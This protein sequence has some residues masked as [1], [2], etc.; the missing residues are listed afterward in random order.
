MPDTV[1]HLFLELFHF[2]FIK[3]LWG[4]HPHSTEDIW[5]AIRNVFLYQEHLEKVQVNCPRSHSSH[6]AQVAL[7]SRPDSPIQ[8]LTMGRDA[9]GKSANHYSLPGISVLGQRTSQV[10]NQG[11][12]GCRQKLLIVREGFSRRD[13]SVFSVRTHARK[14]LANASGQPLPRFLLPKCLTGM[15][16]TH[17][18]S[19]PSCSPLATQTR[20]TGSNAR[21][22][23]LHWPECKAN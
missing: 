11:L 18:P 23:A 13:P 16:L 19:R 5:K 7:K 6:L 1:L 10:W 14:A 4:G 12:R 3:T 22:P 17:H 20:S 2:I 8:L 9:K 21:H 15:A